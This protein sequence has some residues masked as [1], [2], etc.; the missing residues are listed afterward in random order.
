MKFLLIYQLIFCIAS[1]Q[2]TV[3]VP[4]KKVLNQAT[5]FICIKMQGI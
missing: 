1:H 4:N 2:N 5:R 3:N